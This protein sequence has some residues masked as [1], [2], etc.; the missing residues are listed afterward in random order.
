MKYLADLL[1]DHLDNY[2][3]SLEKSAEVASIKA[4]QNAE[5]PNKIIIS[6]LNMERETGVGDSTSSRPFS[7]ASLGHKNKPWFFNAYFVMAAVFDPKRY[8][9]SIEILS[10]AIEFLQ[11][12]YTFHPVKSLPFVVE[13]VTYSI[14]ELNNIWAMMGGHH[15]PA[16]FGKIKLLVYDGQQL[17]G[18]VSRISKTK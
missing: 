18:V 14:Q 6:L 8:A 13:P 9:E 12:N 17:K 1:S 10:A 7:S 15:Y 3:N 4:N 5:V 2:F 11:T 16:F